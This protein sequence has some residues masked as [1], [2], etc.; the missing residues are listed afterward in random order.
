MAVANATSQQVHG[1]QI[2]SDKSEALSLGMVEDDMLGVE[3]VDVACEDLVDIV[4]FRQGFGRIVLV[5]LVGC[6]KAIIS[7]M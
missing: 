6:M 4:C 2:L 3:F 5:S 1:A 7:L